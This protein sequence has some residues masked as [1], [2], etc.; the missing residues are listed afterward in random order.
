MP[1]ADLLDL[2]AKYGAYPVLILWIILERRERKE[3]QKALQQLI[4][5]G[6]KAMTE[7][8]NAFR[9]LRFTLFNGGRPHV[10]SGDDNPYVDQNT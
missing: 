9:A 5:D 10:F 2:I 4:P 3:T 8:T 1:N 7:M 6:I